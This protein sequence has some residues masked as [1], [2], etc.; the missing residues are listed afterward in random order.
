MY[1][2][3]FFKRKLSFFS[4][5]TFFYSETPRVACISFVFFR[6]PVYFLIVWCHF[7]S[8]VC[9]VENYYFFF[10]LITIT[11]SHLYLLNLFLWS[12]LSRIFFCRSQLGFYKKISF[13]RKSSMNYT[14]YKVWWHRDLV[15]KIYFS[16]YVLN[17]L[18][19]HNWHDTKKPMKI[20]GHFIS[21]PIWWAF[22]FF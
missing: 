2:K 14:K 9:L 6:L 20:K 4:F 1:S 5:L 21:Q 7:F 12:L 10:I 17:L 18:L 16:Y 8:M 3:Y 22:L 19:I 13:G 11:G 15:Q